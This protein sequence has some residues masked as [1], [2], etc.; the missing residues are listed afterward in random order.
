M[1][2]DHKTLCEPVTGTQL[3]A[4]NLAAH[5]KTISLLVNK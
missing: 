3:Q 4:I 5:L 2:K 1:V